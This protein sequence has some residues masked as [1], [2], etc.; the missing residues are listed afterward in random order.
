MLIS[1]EG[2]DFAGKSTQIELLCQFLESI[3]KSY[4]V[5]REPGGN[6]VSEAIRAVILDNKHATMIA[7][8]E[9]LLY[10]AAR[11]QLVKSD[12]IPLLAELDVV[13]CDRYY[14]STTAY[15][16]FGRGLD[17]SFITALNA[18]ATG[19]LVPDRTYFL[20]LSVDESY[21]RR[22]AK[23]GHENDRLEAAGRE[24]F[25][26]VRGGYLKIAEEEK[27]RF[28]VLN[29]ARLADEIH[30]DIISDIKKAAL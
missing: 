19:K 16:G 24:F 2:I 11:V 28:R 27:A 30:R 17:R 6:S 13:I 9:L 14:D 23:A 26:R 7:E 10:A 5:V 15:Q 25:E 1:F 20:D 29:A 3:G 18:F 4:R 8:A 12:I 21:A 22:S